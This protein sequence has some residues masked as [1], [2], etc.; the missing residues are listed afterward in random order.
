MPKTLV[1][2]LGAFGL[3]SGSHNRIVDLSFDGGPEKCHEMAVE[4]VS[5]AEFR[6]VLHHF[7]SRTRMEGSCGPA[8]L[9]DGRKPSKNKIYIF[10]SDYDRY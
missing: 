4:W 9:E 8:W 5:W 2:A 3:L 7:S 1:S 10:V 6:R